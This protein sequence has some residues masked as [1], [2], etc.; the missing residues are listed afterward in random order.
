MSE[1][2][3]RGRTSPATLLF[4]IIVPA[5][6]IIGVL[7]F[8]WVQ[9]TTQEAQESSHASALRTFGLA[10]P[11]RNA[12]DGRF[13]DNDGDLVADPPSDAAELVDPPKLVFCYVAQEDPTGYQAAFKDFIEHLAKVTGKPVEYLT[14]TSTTDQLKA[15]R[16]GKLHVTGFNTGSVPIAV[17]LCGFVPAC[18]LAAPDGNATLHTEIIVPADSP[19]K[20]PSDLKGREL[21]LTEFT[22]NAGCKAPI[23]LLRRHFGLE[24]ERDYLPRFY[25]SYDNSIEGIARKEIQAAAVAS[26]VLERAVARGDISKSQYRTIFQSESFPTACFGMAHNLKPELAAKV[27]QAFETFNW[28]GT[29]ME[30]EFAQSN[31]GRFVTASFK[32]DWSLIRA[33]DEQI[34][35]AY[36]LE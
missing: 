17:Y 29:S 13:V 7:W 11:V 2:S 32:D 3:R 12:L 4:M 28:Q 27:K 10:S 35:N 14:V 23:V 36:K 30:K 24:P 26:D 21:T 22:S 16:D 31:Q 1:F 6:V 5:A 8:I 18:K 9:K 20:A 34:G 33:I 19:L 15:L 25:G